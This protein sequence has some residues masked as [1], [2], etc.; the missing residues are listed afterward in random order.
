MTNIGR[1]NQSCFCFPSLVLILSCYCWRRLSH[2]DP[3]RGTPNIP[4]GCTNTSLQGVFII[5]IVRAR[6]G[7]PQRHYLSMMVSTRV[8]CPNGICTWQTGGQTKKQLFSPSLQ[9]VAL[10]DRH[11]FLY[12]KVDICGYL[13]DNVDEI[14]V[15]VER[16]KMASHLAPRRSPSSRVALV[17]TS[18]SHHPVWRVHGGCRAWG[19]VAVL[20][21]IHAA[22][23]HTLTSR[24]C[25]ARHADAGFP[26]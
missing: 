7:C 10:P 4:I 2:R 6:V 11:H 21:V 14:R 9:H 26:G 23:Q 24:A 25:K 20:T 19:E 1:R 5:E 16:R 12:D 17:A 18:P 15:T 22:P 13:P 3:P 8:G